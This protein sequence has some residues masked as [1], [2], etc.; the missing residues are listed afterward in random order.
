MTSPTVFEGGSYAIVPARVAEIAELQRELAAEKGCPVIDMHTLTADKKD[1]FRDDYVHPEESGYAF[2]AEQVAQHITAY[3]GRAPGAPVNLSVRDG[4]KYTLVSWEIVDKGDLP[5]ISYDV[6]VNGELNGTSYGL[7]YR[8]GKLQNGQEYEIRIKAK[9]AAGESEFSETITAHP[10]ASTPVVTGI[11][12][13]GVY[14]LAAGTPTVTWTTSATAELDG[15][16]FAKNGKIS[17]PGEHTLVITNDNVVVTLVFTVT[18]SS[19]VLG[20]I[21]KDGSVT[22]ADALAALR[23]SLKL[24][25]ADAAALYRGDADGDGEI[26]VSDALIILRIAAQ[27]V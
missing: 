19:F 26:T 14:D 13:G 25:E 21:D 16:P 12:D 23:F 6:Y 15:E 24:A 3:P 27:L 4:S 20:D 2:I 10:T 11:E 22:V 8:V 18:D 1:L 17:E 5:S 7:M 9:N